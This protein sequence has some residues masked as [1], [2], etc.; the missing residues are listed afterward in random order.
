MSNAYV[1]KLLARRA[2]LLKELSTL[3]HLIHGSWF[4]RYSTCSRRN[5]SCHT[6]NR[7]GPRHYLVVQEEGRQRQK[8]VPKSQVSA[9]LKGIEQYH[10][11]QEIVEEI[12]QINLALMKERA[13]ERS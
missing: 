3:S 4:E 13:Y 2:I 11:L 1:E 5:C 10:R 7:H 9:A 8:Y 12:T 6:G